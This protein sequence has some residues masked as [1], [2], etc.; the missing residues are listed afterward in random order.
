MTR[1]DELFRE[2]EIL[3]S[4]MSRYINASLRINE[5]LEYDI[6]LQEVLDAA[7]SLTDARLGIIT[8][9]DNEG[10][11]RNF[12]ASGMTEQEASMLWAV[13]NAMRLFKYL[14]GVAE[15]LRVPD[16]VGHIRSMGLPDI[17]LPGA[18]VPVASFLSAPLLHRGERV[19]N[20]FLAGKESQA[21][22]TDEDEES[23]TL[24]ASQAALVISNAR[25][26]QEETAGSKRPGN[27]NRH[28]SCGRCGVRCKDRH[29]NVIESGG[30]EDS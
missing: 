1:E 13:P 3:R 30:E 18:V 5:S 11:V 21:E 4:R 17:P 24:F 15:R 29:P 25:R 20:F 7:R 16:L 2:N 19:G 12:L 28:F 27:P 14:N 26:Y 6:V 22:F 9:Q 10:S 8:I 23:L